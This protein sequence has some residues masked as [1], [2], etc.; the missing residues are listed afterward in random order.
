MAAVIAIG[1]R[2]AF[3]RQAATAPPAKRPM[4]RS[5]ATR[6]NAPSGRALGAPPL[7]GIIALPRLWTRSSQFSNQGTLPRTD[8]I[9][10]FGAGARSR[11]KGQLCSP[12]VD[13][14]CR[15]SRLPAA[16]DD[17]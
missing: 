5:R 9:E 12:R 17:G 10:M 7:F 6:G 16:A 1:S 15:I 13:P 14:K 11:Q 2:T 8:A 4:T 3:Q